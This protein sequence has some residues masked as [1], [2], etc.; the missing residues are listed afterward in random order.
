MGVGV[1]RASGYAA[2]HG[3]STPTLAAGAER[4]GVGRADMARSG[5]R[6][7]GDGVGALGMEKARTA[8]RRIGGDGSFMAAELRGKDAFRQA[9]MREVRDLLRGRIVHICYS[10]AHEAAVHLLR[11]CRS[12]RSPRRLSNPKH[13]RVAVGCLS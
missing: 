11:R 9:N 2:Y 3:F 8:D 10:I 4:D 1:E 5:Y 6:R 12:Q 13:S 7:R